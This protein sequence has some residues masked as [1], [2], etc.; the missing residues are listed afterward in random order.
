[1]PTWFFAP[2]LPLPLPLSH[3]SPPSRFSPS[4]SP[5]AFPFCIPHSFPQVPFCGFVRCFSA[6][7][8]PSCPAPVLPVLLDA[9]PSGS[10][11]FC[12]A[13][14]AASLPALC[15][16][17]CPCIIS[18]FPLIVC[19][20]SLQNF[21]AKKEPREKGLPLPVALVVLVY[22]GFLPSALLLLLLLLEILFHPLPCFCGF[23]LG[24]RFADSLPLCYLSDC[25]ALRK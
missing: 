8:C 7:L 14:S 18:H 16:V 25:V 20:S 15:C 13:P 24:L 2:F 6:S 3:P 5:F 21:E 12:S 10:L 19:P 17:V 1:M 11:P 9:V 4:L 23:P 22:S